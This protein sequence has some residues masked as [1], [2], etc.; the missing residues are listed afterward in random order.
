[1]VLSALGWQL[2]PKLA[3]LSLVVVAVVKFAGVAQAWAKEVVLELSISHDSLVVSYG[4]WLSMPK[5]Y[6]GTYPLIC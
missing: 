6:V 2:I 5:A 3:K 1:M 4:F